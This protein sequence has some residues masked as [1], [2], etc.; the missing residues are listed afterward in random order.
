M[1]VMNDFNSQ[2]VVLPFLGTRDYL[3]GTTLFE[4]L[5]NKFAQAEDITLKINAMILSNCVLLF[6]YDKEKA[7][8]KRPSPATFI[9]KQAGNIKKIGIAPLES[10]VPLERVAYDEAKIV[11][12]TTFKNESAFLDKPLHCSFIKTVVAINKELLNRNILI[13]NSIFQIL[14]TRIDLKY[15][16]TAFSL[17]QIHLPVKNQTG[18]FSISKII[19]DDEHVGDLYFS[20]MEK[21]ND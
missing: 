16:P 8:L 5:E 17:L 9:C 21:N 14:F 7:T 15:I 6:D 2:E 3:H 13:N 10:V 19:L 12:L 11:G 1:I 20:W 18:K 4:L